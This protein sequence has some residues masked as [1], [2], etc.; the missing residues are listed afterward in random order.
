[1]P[2]TDYQNWTQSRV[3][4]S[5]FL[6]YPS[7][8]IQKGKFAPGKIIRGKFFLIKMFFFLYKTP[9]SFFFL[10][11]EKD[12]KGCCVAIVKKKS[13]LTLTLKLKWKKKIPRLK[14]EGE[15]VKLSRHLKRKNF[16][17]LLNSSSSKNFR[18]K[19]VSKRGIWNAADNVT[20]KTSCGRW[21]PK[22]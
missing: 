4:S 14:C 11:S 5:I 22:R 12:G 1:M 17:M 8:F 16:K 3:F 13:H 21:F 2:D 18:E 9:E 7:L 20:V 19:F 10:V 6:N 15:K